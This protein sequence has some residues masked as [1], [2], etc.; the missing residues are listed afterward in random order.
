MEDNAKLSFYH[1]TSNAVVKMCFWPEWRPLVRAVC[2]G[3]V[4]G[5]LAEVQQQN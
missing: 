5:T 2:K 1:L 4:E 3:D